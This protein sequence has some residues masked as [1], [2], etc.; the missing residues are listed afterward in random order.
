MKTT[1]TTHLT[2]EV[3]WTGE[4]FRLCDPMVYHAQERKLQPGEGEVFVMTLMRPEDAA[5]AGQYRY[6]FGQVIKPLSAY[7]GYPQAWWHELL[8]TLFYP[9]DGSKRTSLTQLSHAELAEFISTS[10]EFAR[11][12]FFQAFDDAEE[13]AA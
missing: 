9:K 11:V 5:T 4:R 8:K 12:E 3:E 10:E 6:L 1:S 2:A 13:L 7:T